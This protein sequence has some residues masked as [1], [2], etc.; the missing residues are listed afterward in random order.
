MLPLVQIA[1]ALAILVAY[2]ST[3]FGLTDP[4]SR[5]MLILNL[6]GSAVLAVLA[7]LDAQWGFFL[8]EGAWAAVSAWTLGS[9]AKGVVAA[10]PPG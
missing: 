3:Q 5:L 7:Y 4:Y 8:L 1:G 10:P 9:K 2:A 6:A